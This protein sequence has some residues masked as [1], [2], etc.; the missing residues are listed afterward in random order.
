[1]SSRSRHCW[2]CLVLASA[3]GGSTVPPREKPALAPVSQP[4]EPFR[5]KVVVI[6]DQ[7]LAGDGV[8][9]ASGEATASAA[10]APAT[11]PARQNQPSVGCVTVK[12]W[13]RYSSGY[14]H[15]VTLQNGCTKVADCRVSTDVNPTPIRVTLAPSASE[16]VLTFRGS[17]A[18]TFQAKVD[19]ATAP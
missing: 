6:K 3:C 13:T 5:R 12:A 18:Y 14:D 16:T 2:C 7:G 19:C 8:P 11:E 9:P 17:P 4:D 10:P 15:L 1:M